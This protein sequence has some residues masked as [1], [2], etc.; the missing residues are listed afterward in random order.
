MVYKPT[1]EI[2]LKTW[3]KL[4]QRRNKNS[5]ESEKSRDKFIFASAEFWRERATEW[6]LA[7]RKLDS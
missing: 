2:L 7:E 4:E 6:R 1:L 3:D 5:K